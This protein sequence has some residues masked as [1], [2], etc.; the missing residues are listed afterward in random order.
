MLGRHVRIAEGLGLLV[1]AVKDTR[2]LARQRGLGRRARLP[3]EA[4]DLP[5]RFSAELGDVEPRLLEQGH[6]DAIVLR[7]QSEEQMGV[8][9]DGIAARAGQR[10]RLLQGFG[11]L[12]GQTFGSDHSRLWGRRPPKATSVPGKSAVLAEK[13][14]GVAQK[15]SLTPLWYASV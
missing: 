9:D 7:Q 3:R 4:V 5:F 2:H 1:G 8:V 12:D 13:Q 15:R 14:E 11:R 6:D 10:A